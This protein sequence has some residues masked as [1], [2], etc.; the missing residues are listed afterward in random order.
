MKLSIDTSESDITI[1]GLDD[2]Q[3]QFETKKHRSQQLR[4]LIE[5]TLKKQKKDLKEVKQIEVNLGPGS[6]TGLR[7]GIAVANALGWALKVPIN[8]KEVGKLVEPK[9]G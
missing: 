2:R 4:G 7:V 9:Y 6:F 1:I 5:Q 8:G 3:W